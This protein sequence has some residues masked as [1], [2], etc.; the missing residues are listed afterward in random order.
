MDAAGKIFG[1]TFSWIPGLENRLSHNQDVYSRRSAR[2]VG[3]LSFG[4][5]KLGAD[6]INV[7]HK[8]KVICAYEAELPCWAHLLAIGHN[9]FRC[10]GVST[11]DVG[12]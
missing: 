12:S 2:C 10:F 11:N 1:P 4:L 5:N 6:E 3:F 8:R 7:L 9:F